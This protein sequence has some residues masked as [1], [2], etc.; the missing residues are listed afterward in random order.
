MNLIKTKSFELAVIARGNKNSDKLAMVLPGKLDTKDYS[1]FP[2]HLEYLASKGFYAISLD[3]PGTWDSPG[4]IELYTTTNY[5]KAVNELI[6]YFGNKPTFLMGHSRGGTV[7]ALVGAS[8]P[9]VLGFACI[10]ANYG[11]QSSPSAEA[12]KTGIQVSYRD[13]PPGTSK[14]SEQKEFALP[15]AYFKDGEQ[16]VN[17]SSVLKKCNKPKILLYGTHDEFTNPEKV[18]DVYN[19]LPDPKMIHK[20]DTDHDYRYHPEIIE[21]VNEV[22]GQFLDNFVSS[23]QV[24]VAVEHREAV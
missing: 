14:T 4:P 15:I 1:C 9:H 20:L 6:E 7:S 16:Y 23:N 8:N 5:I 3:P 10:M 11:V 18:K 22:V 19:D 2:S 13:L 21:E 24:E 12:L 17:V